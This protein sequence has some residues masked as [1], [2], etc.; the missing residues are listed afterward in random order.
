[1]LLRLSEP[2]GGFLRRNMPAENRWYSRDVAAIAAARGLDDVAPFFVDA[3]PGAAAGADSWPRAGLT[4]TRFSNNHLG[5]ALTWFA[6]ALLVAWGGWRI[7][8]DERALRRIH[9]G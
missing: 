2:G 6:L 3:E 8:R 5:Y 7:A 1:G 4:I 9:P